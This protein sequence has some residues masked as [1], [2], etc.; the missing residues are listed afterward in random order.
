MIRLLFTLLICS[1]NLIG[2]V[3]SKK[4]FVIKYC[5]GHY[6]FGETGEFE[7]WENFKFVI[8]EKKFILKEFQSITN[9][10]VYNPETQKNNQKI[11]DT[12]FEFPN[13]KFEKTEFENLISQ[14]NQNQNNFN[15][16]FINAN[17]SKKISKKQI[18]EIAKKQDQSYWFIDDV[19][20]KTDDFGKQ[21]V[22][23]IQNFENFEKYIQDAEPK[24]DKLVVLSDGWNFAE[25]GYANSS[26]IGRLNFNS[27]LGQPIQLT[28]NSQVINLNVNLI[29]LKILPKKSLLYKKVEFENIKADYIN[30]FIQKIN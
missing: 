15:I 4:E 1:S 28:N 5:I 12:L 20:K 14:L 23:E 8:N 6:N 29:L 10:Y 22:Q 25:L 18:L 3:P 16:D 24:I 21:K 13:K 17:L 11:S 7:K 30:W 19:T 9:Q 26:P 2:Q 27:V